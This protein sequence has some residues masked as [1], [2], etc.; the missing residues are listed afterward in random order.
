MSPKSHGR[1]KG[2]GRIPV[3]HRPPVRELTELDHVLHE[4]PGLRDSNRLEAEAIASA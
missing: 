4:A 3:R 2:R 1:P